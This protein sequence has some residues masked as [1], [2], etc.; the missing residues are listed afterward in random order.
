MAKGAIFGL[1]TAAI[2][3]GVLLVLR[4]YK[5]DPALLVMGGAV[6]GALSF[7]R[8]NASPSSSDAR[9]PSCGLHEKSPISFVGWLRRAVAYS[10]WR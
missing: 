8:P 9:V 5:V 7:G 2:A 3:V 10:R 6:V 4:Q 1:E